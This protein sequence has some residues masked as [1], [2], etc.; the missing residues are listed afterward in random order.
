MTE[1]RRDLMIK[2]DRPATGAAL[3]SPAQWQA[4][5]TICQAALPVRAPALPNRSGQ[6]LKQGAGRIETREPARAPEQ[7]LRHAPGSGSEN[8]G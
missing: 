4:L 6:G 5:K 7:E 3:L 2:E 1:A 8:G